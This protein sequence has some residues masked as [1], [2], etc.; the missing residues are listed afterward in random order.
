MHEII[1]AIVQQK[2]TRSGSIRRVGCAGNSFDCNASDIAFTALDCL[3]KMKGC[4]LN[5]NH[6]EDINTNK[7]ETGVHHVHQSGQTDLGALR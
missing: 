1:D 5:V 6:R 2:N 7:C 3:D 4:N